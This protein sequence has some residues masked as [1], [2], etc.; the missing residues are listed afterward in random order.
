[1]SDLMVSFS[2]EITIATP[3]SEDVIIRSLEHNEMIILNKARRH[4]VSDDGGTKPADSAASNLKHRVAEC[5]QDRTM[6][7]MFSGMSVG[8]NAFR[9]RP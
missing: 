3:N 2:H 6:F 7:L 4:V 9:V 5:T 8:G 1:M